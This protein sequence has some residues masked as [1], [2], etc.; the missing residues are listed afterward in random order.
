MRYSI[1]PRDQIYDLKLWLCYKSYGFLSFAENMDKN[2]GKSI[3]KKLNSKHCQK[4]HHH[5]KKSATDPLKA[6]S[7]RAI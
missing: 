6:T 1:K 4:L 3:S 5:A 2:I 7:K